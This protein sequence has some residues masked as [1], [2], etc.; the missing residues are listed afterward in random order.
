MGRRSK[1][2]AAAAE[3]GGAADGGGVE[4][5][6][7]DND[8]ASTVVVQAPRDSRFIWQLEDKN[9]CWCSYSGEVC[10]ALTAAAVLGRQEV[11]VEAGPR[12]KLKIDLETLVQRGKTTKK[13]IR[14][15]IEKEDCGVY[16]SIEN[17]G[18]LAPGIAARIEQMRD[19]GSVA[20]LQGMGVLSCLPP[21]LVGEEN[22]DG[23]KGKGS[24]EG[25][26]EG[27]GRM[28]GE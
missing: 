23:K 10:E 1:K 22:Q 13:K 28:E 25:E 8:A 11:D 17:G 26:R 27:E 15:L 4:D 18:L 9:D 14:C 2:R 16:W 5:N 6:K 12:S 24:K 20:I 3:S 21:P 7:S 19:M